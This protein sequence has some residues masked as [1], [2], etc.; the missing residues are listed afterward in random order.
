MPELSEQEL[1]LNSDVI[2]EGTVVKVGEG[3]WSNPNMVSGKRNVLQSDITVN[4]NEMISGEYNSDEVIVRV[5]K[6]YDK[7]SNIKVE[8]DGY[9]DFSIGEHIVLFLSRDDS[10]LAT[11]ENYFVLT[12]MKQGKWSFAES[13]GVDSKIISKEVETSSATQI[14]ITDL[15]KRIEEEKKNNPNWHLIRNEQ[16]EQTIKKNKELFEE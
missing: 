3:K 6:G 9:P 13:N 15:K 10:D 2:I 1:I 12:G 8:S 14:S 16:K 7:K 4:I 11:N 5:D